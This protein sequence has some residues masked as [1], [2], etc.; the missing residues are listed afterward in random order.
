MN[1]NA[2]WN[3]VLCIYMPQKKHGP[4]TMA[5]NERVLLKDLGQRWLGLSMGHRDEAKVPLYASPRALPRG[6][7]RILLGNIQFF[8]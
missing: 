3:G 2:S 8:L 7:F 5:R 1:E 6:R 4:E